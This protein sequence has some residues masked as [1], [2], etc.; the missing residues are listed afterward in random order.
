MP[1]SKNRRRRSPSRTATTGGQTMMENL[2]VEPQ[3]GKLVPT[4]RVIDVDASRER[5]LVE[6]TASP[7]TKEPIVRVGARRKRPGGNA[8]GATAPG[9]AP[10]QAS[11]GATT[12]RPENRDDAV[13]GAEVEFIVTFGGGTLLGEIEEGDALTVSTDSRGI[14]SVGF[15]LG[16]IT[17]A[18]PVYVRRNPDDSYY[19]QALLIE[20]E[21][22]AQSET[23]ALVL[24]RP[25]TAIAVPDEPATLVRTDTHW[26]PIIE[27][28]AGMW[29][30][31]MN[32][33]VLDRFAEMTLIGKNA[34][35]AM[36]LVQDHLNRCGNC[37][38]E[39]QALLV[40]LR[41]IE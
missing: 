30:D 1:K 14:A 13:A 39:F 27:G 41:A 35:E 4:A 29:A 33:Q 36:P 17:E 5:P 2:A 11:N 15:K 22:V 7:A 23:G 38:E 37:R 25:F 26:P 20:V 16:Q 12:S 18:S 40:A 24:D 3:A 10:V 21:T 6:I 9:T 31:T 8:A 28:L 32:F 19:T 34:A